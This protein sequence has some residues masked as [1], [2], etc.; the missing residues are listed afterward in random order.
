MEKYTFTIYFILICL[1][2][3]RWV[4]NIVGRNHLEDLSSDGRI[5]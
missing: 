4:G 1:R 5:I 3:M 2:G